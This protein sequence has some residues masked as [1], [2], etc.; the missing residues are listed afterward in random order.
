MAYG[1]FRKKAS[2]EFFLCIRILVE[3]GLTLQRLP[4]KTD[5]ES[6]SLTMAT[7]VG[8]RTIRMALIDRLHCLCM[9][10]VSRSCRVTDFSTNQA[11]VA[12]T[13]SVLIV[14]I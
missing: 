11:G 14:T 2:P 13:D 5:R 10:G 9:T 8:R 7:K 12:D 1:C 3:N 6:V 4:V